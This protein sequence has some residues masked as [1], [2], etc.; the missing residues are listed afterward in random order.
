MCSENRLLTCI[1]HCQTTIFIGVGMVC[2]LMLI[3]PTTAYAAAPAPSTGGLTL[4]VDAAGLDSTGRPGGWTPVQVTVSNQGNDFRGTLVAQIYYSI[5]RATVVVP[6]RFERAIAVPH[7]QQ[8]RVMLFLPF[9]TAPTTIHGVQVELLDN[10]GQVVATQ[11]Q[12]LYVAQPA[13]VF[14]GML[15][16]QSSGF[17]PLTNAV[18]PNQSNAIVTAS[19]HAT[20]MP[21]SSIILANFDVIVLADFDTR[22]LSRAQF[23]A[24]RTWV[25]R[26]GVL[27]EVGGPDW[28]RTLLPLQADLLPVDVHGT[29]SLPAKTPL[30]PSVP[31]GST[32][33]QPPFSLPVSI[34]TPHTQETA[35]VGETVLMAGT[36][37][38]L[39]RQPL[40]QGAICYLAVDPLS[41]P[42]LS[43]SGTSALWGRLL[44][45]LLG[46]SL[47]LSNADPHYLSG[48]GDLFTRSGILS[49]L[50][51]DITVTPWLLA[52]LL[53]CY[54]L[55]LGPGR[56]WFVRRYRRPRW[57][58]RI[59]L[60]S[61]VCFSLLSYGIAFYQH[62]A[63]LVDDSVSLVRL[64]QGGNTAA[65][66]TYLGVFDPNPGD[67]QLHVPDATQSSL[68]QP[69]SG[70]LEG[71][72]LAY[73]D[74]FAT[75]EYRG[76]GTD[77][78]LQNLSP[79]SFHAFVL[80]RDRQLHGGLLPQLM[81]RN[82]RV[83]GTI[84]N[85]L[86]TRLSDVYLL[87]PNGIVALGHLAAGETRRVDAAIQQRTA[88]DSTL[89]AQIARSKGLAPGYFPYA[90]N[91]Q[92]HKDTQRHVALLS[93]LSG[94][95]SSFAPC[96]GSCIGQSILHDGNL[97][98]QRPGFTGGALSSSNDSLLLTNAPATLIAWA[99]QPLDGSESITINGAQPHGF[100]DNLIQMPLNIS[101]A[102]PVR[103][104]PG[105]ITGQITA[106]QGYGIEAALP[107]TYTI[108][109]NSSMTLEFAFPA[110]I[111]AQI[112]QLT[113]TVPQAL[114]PSILASNSGSGPSSGDKNVQVVQVQLYNW[115]T[116]TWDT[117]SLTKQTFVITNRSAYIGPGNR[118]LLQVIDQKPISGVLYVGRPTLSLK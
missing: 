100:H 75:I 69:V 37:P 28:Q 118:V 83:V 112:K 90:H 63:A 115:L 27:I 82:G 30:L 32:T 45:R 97:I 24:L 21:T 101:V 8:Q 39:V 7:G 81:L 16:G 109:A 103:L 68:L 89:A 44:L 55:I 111:V 74:R 23:A 22:T 66:T 14:I 57:S 64:G 58:W 38:V 102:A 31:P 25:N 26:G 73:D 49:M 114:Y 78:L 95:G 92:P 107:D 34:A 17:G 117:L 29:G 43:W 85:T 98:T 116:G 42:L 52:V 1:L 40:G 5:S 2:F 12:R 106:V 9:A 48:P 4:S 15:T 65:I 99:D 36:T 93:A 91:G 87:F 104:A 88:Q 53:T 3:I 50:I 20:T 46:D 41:E 94:V 77:A 60:A 67:V 61:I 84:S 79:W 70:T 108:S 105:I 71:N 110:S 76:D 113:F 72:L 47:L 11:D 59:I 6:Q 18:L 80:E 54:A 56:L 86:E 51:P 33:E 19:L 13:D 10:Q 96:E 35:V 62:G